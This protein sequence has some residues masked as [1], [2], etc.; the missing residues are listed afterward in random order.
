[1]HCGHHSAG[2]GRIAGTCIVA[3]IWRASR[4]LAENPRSRG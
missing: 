3:C 4:N 2:T 1:V